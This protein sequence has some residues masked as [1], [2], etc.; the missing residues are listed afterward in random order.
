VAKVA[1]LEGP[2]EEF[3]EEDSPDRDYVFSQ[4]FKLATVV[5]CVLRLKYCAA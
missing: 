5:I 1:N 2:E 3:V 4:F